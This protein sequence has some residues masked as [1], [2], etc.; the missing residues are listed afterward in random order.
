MSQKSRRRYQHPRSRIENRAGRAP[1][2]SP[3]QTGLDSA[4]A[5]PI[6]SAMSVMRELRRRVSADRPLA[7]FEPCLPRPAKTPPAGPGWIHEIKH[8]GFRIIARRDSDRVRLLT[9]HRVD[10]AKRVALS[11]RPA[12]LLGEGQEPSRAGGETR[13]RG[14]LGRPMSAGAVKPRRFPPPCDRRIFARNPCAHL[15]WTLPQLTH[16]MAMLSPSRASVRRTGGVSS[17]DQRR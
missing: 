16:R 13:G 3:P 8:D 17:S 5:V 12:R 10:L 9:R 7:R 4:C 6:F 1:A 2:R 11:R 14:G 15:L